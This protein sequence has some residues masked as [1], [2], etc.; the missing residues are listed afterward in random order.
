MHTAHYWLILIEILQ[1]TI[2]RKII[3]VNFVFALLTE[4]QILQSSSLPQIINGVRLD[5]KSMQIKASSV[6]IVRAFRMLISL[7]TGVG[8]IGGWHVANDAKKTTVSR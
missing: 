7:K 6:W 2:V 4:I 3:E 8:A 5:P 1:H